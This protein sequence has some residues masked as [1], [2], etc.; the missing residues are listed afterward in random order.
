METAALRSIAEAVASYPPAS[1]LPANSNSPPFAQ[2]HAEHGRRIIQ[3]Q[4]ELFDRCPGQTAAKSANLLDTFRRTQ[5]LFEERLSLM[6]G[7]H[8]RREATKQVRPGPAFH[9]Q[10][11][12]ARTLERI[13]GR[14]SR[15]VPA[16]P[17]SVRE[18]PVLRQ[19][20]FQ[21]PSFPA[22][23]HETLID[24]AIVAAGMAPVAL[25]GWALLG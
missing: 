18:L 1:L 9:V 21:L 13:E 19:K 23:R 16:A 10:Q 3:Q 6:D 20:G 25:M 8:A 4:R 14:S 11:A 2:A 7:S 17:P 22:S 12:A 5:F 15:V 24:A